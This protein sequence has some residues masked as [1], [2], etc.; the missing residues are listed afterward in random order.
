MR[1]FPLLYPTA[2][3]ALL[4]GI[5]ERLT[6]MGRVASSTRAA[7]EAIAPAIEQARRQGWP[8][9]LVLVELD[10]RDLVLSLR[11]APLP[12]TD[13]PRPTLRPFDPDRWA[14]SVV[15]RGRRHLPAEE[16]TKAVARAAGVDVAIKKPRVDRSKERAEA[17]AI[18]DAHGFDGA[19]RVVAAAI[20]AAKTP[21][22]R[23]YF[24][25]VRRFIRPPA[26]SPVEVS[27]AETL[28]S[29]TRRAD[30]W[31]IPGTPKPLDGGGWRG[32]KTRVLVPGSGRPVEL[33]AH[34]A[35]LPMSRVR[36]SHDPW[37]FS[38]AKGY[39]P[40]LQ[41][42]DYRS[43][44][45]ERMKV[46]RQTSAFDPDLVLSTDTTA[47]GGPPIVTA[48][49]IVLG[50]NS[51]A[52]T[53]A[54]VMK[55]RPG[56]YTAA[57]ARAL[58]AHCAAIGL[59]SVER[60]DG[61]VLVRVLDDKRTPV[62]VSAMLNASFTQQMGDAA[63]SA[64]LGSRIPADVLEL[65]AEELVERSF[66][67]AV[68]AAGER[69]VS[70]L[71]KAGIIT[72]HNAATWLMQ[73]K[74]RTLPELS[75]RGADQL[76]G[77]LVGALVGDKELLTL[78]T[79]SLHDLYERIAPIVLALEARPERIP[80]MSWRLLDAMRPALREVPSV[81]GMTPDRF[82]QHYA[83]AT[84]GDDA[85]PEVRTDALV[86]G[87]LW[88]VWRGRSRP[89]AAAKQ[90]LTYYRSIPPEAREA[91]LFDRTPTELAKAGLDQAALMESAL[92]IPVR[93]IRANGPARWL[94]EV[95]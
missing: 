49:G 67:D 26:P 93:R 30:D 78:T 13:N 23:E 46:E 37:T 18:V 57:L 15:R 69:I 68:D 53:I 3:L 59:A 27:R 70:S 8:V 56:D 12:R 81:V 19:R 34:Y 21:E 65:L 94:S 28:A 33:A 84:L 83:N 11:Q 6:W 73:R 87:L 2:D 91:G 72:P 77:A 80:G 71:Q 24:R 62:D 9:S 82:R 42:R 51:R 14:R 88:W 22:T 60:V 58:S 89:A 74:G 7:I 10:S 79:A 90:L 54:R 76:R 92:D 29:A 5:G 66:S 50:G 61:H 45:G 32:S 1:I 47:I 35:L 64:S 40:E 20:E 75:R 95:A 39:P 86:A 38:P 63:A 55:E 25:A 52:M 16:V 43:D 41:E 48:D 44:H 17:A 4:P 85:V 31:C 36:T